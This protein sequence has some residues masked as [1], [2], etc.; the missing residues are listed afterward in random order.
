MET[1]GDGVMGAAQTG[2]DEVEEGGTQPG[3]V[4]LWQGG[5]KRGVSKSDLEEETTRFTIRG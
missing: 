1:R 4:P 3:Q 5:V 2:R